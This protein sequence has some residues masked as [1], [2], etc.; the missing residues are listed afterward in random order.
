M[1]TVDCPVAMHITT[2]AV[3][4]WASAQLSRTDLIPLQDKCTFLTDFKKKDEILNSVVFFFKC[5]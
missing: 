3:V 4:R 1:K 5:L 2:T